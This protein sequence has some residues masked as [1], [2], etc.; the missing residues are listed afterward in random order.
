[1]RVDYDGIRRGYEWA[2]NTGIR[3]MLG[4]LHEAMEDGEVTRQRIRYI[5]VICDT[6]EGEGGHSRR[7]GAMT[8]E[9]FSEWDDDSREAYLSGRYDESCEACDGSGKVQELDT[10]SLTEDARAWVEAYERA[11][12]EAAEA[13]AAERRWGC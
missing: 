11:V 8:S 12:Y 5:W 9:E 7:F 4:H 1:M 6:C 13:E 3:A 2:V 10:E